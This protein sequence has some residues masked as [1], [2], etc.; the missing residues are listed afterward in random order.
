MQPHVPLGQTG[1]Y[2]A[3]HRLGVGAA[4]LLVQHLAAAQ[5]FHLAAQ[6]VQFGLA[7]HFVE[8]GAEFRRHAAQTGGELA[9]P[10]HEQRQVLGTHHHQGDNAD[11]QEFPCADVG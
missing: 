3:H 1:L 5:G 11:E 6:F 7:A 8:A 4:H 10:A 2:L 9:E